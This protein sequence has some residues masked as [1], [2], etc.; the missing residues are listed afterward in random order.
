MSDLALGGPLHKASARQGHYAFCSTSSESMG[1]LST[2]ST[3]HLVHFIFLFFFFILL[4]VFFM[5][6]LP[7]ILLYI[8]ISLQKKKISQ[9]HTSVQVEVPAVENPVMIVLL[10]CCRLT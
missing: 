2:F 8:Y 10:L 3:L 7:H 9:F 6:L 1:Y 4:C 5:Y